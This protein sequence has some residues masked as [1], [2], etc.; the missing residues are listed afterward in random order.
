[1]CTAYAVRS[2][3]WWSCA[4]SMKSLVR[5]RRPVGRHVPRFCLGE[6][7]GH[8]GDWSCFG[9]EDGQNNWL[10]KQR[11][12]CPSSGLAPQTCRRQAYHSAVQ[13]R[14]D[15]QTNQLPSPL[16][17]PPPSVNHV[18]VQ[19]ASWSSLT[20][21]RARGPIAS[22]LSSLLRLSSSPVLV[23]SILPHTSQPSPY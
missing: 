1:M 7:A 16:F 10:A 4:V 9:P 2:I 3:C 13:E 20:G 21:A 8:D 11:I 23:R 18:R 17:S 6:P 22:K 19:F 14:A 12:V 5:I 15:R